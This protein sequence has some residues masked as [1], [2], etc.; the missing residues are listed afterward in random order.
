LIEKLIRQEI[1]NSKE[2]RGNGRRSQK[3]MDAFIRGI[4][5]AYRAL[6]ENM[7]A[8]SVAY[9][10]KALADPDHWWFLLLHNPT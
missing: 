6:S 10:K 4:W 8:E 9:N 5:S 2:L 3:E 1:E 7:A